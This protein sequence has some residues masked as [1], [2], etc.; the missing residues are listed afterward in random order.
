MLLFLS[1]LPQWVSL[2][3][4]VVLPTVLAVCGLIFSRRW[5]SPD[6]L[7]SNNE[8]AGFKFATVGAIYSVLV[9]FAVIIVWEKFNEAEVAVVQEAGA[10][11][12]LFRLTAGSEPEKVAVRAALGTY[13]KLAVERDWPQMAKEKSSREATKALDNL[14][15]VALHLTEDG[16]KQPALFI[17][18]FKQIDSITQARR[19]RLHLATGVVPKVVWLV[20]SCGA[21]LT[22]GFTFFFGN[23]NLRAQAV[24]TGILSVLVFLALFTIVSIDHPFTGPSNVGSEP[25]RAV[26]EDFST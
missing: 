22:V 6:R 20:L 23:K 17:E 10:A 2:I 21:V 16:T 24:M 25:L 26:L 11:A 5:L 18:I 15:T 19:T 12:T 9:A 4:L 8:I 14:Y 7:T 3:L 13:L 1:G